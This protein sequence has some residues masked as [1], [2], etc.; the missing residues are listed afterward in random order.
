MEIDEDELRENMGK[1]N[2]L[3]RVVEEVSRREI[4]SFELD[5]LFSSVDLTEH[6]TCS[7]KQA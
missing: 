1:S 3:E 4:E 6:L 2:E 5:N 7:V